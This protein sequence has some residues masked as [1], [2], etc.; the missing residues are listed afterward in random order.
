MLTIKFQVLGKK[1]T[2]RV[3][4]MRRYMKKN[5]DDSLAITHVSKRRVD[6]SPFGC[7]RDTVMHELVHCYL[8]EMCT[9][10]ATIDADELEEIF[11]EMLAHR[12]REL[13]RLGEKLTRKVKRFRK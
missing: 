4:G 11:A 12:G 6:L 2:L 1:W 13:L 5:G 3:M 10:S 7:N 9:H 8:A